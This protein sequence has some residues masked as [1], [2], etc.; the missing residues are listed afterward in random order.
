M[1]FDTVIIGGGLS[2]LVCGVKLLQQGQ[3]CVIISSGQSALHFSSGSFDLLNKLPDG[4][5]VVNPKQSV[6]KLIEN[7][8]E[9]PYSKIGEERFQSLADEALILLKDS[10]IPVRGSAERN[11]YRVSPMGTLKSTWLTLSDLL[12]SDVESKLPWKRVS[13]FNAIGFLDFHPRFIADEFFKLG[14]ESDIHLFNLPE[15]DLL[16][17]NP[18]EMRST[19]IARVFEHKE[20]IEKLI[21]IIKTNSKETDA[22]VLPAIIGL[23]N[24]EI[25]NFLEREIAKPVCIIPTLPP[26]ILGIRTQQQLHDHFVT[27]GGVYMLGDHVLNAELE[28]YKVKKVFS[29]NHGDI[30]F[31]AKNYVLATGSYFSQGL[32]STNN[33]VFEPVFNLDVAFT[34]DRQEWYQQDMFDKQPYQS[35]GVRTTECFKGLKNGKEF[36][37]LYVAGAI[38]E[39]FNPLKE[40]SGGGVSI[41]SALYVAETILNGD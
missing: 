5:E 39:G 37:N 35:F 40:G 24:T 13:I 41:L 32:L 6:A 2:G 12:I 29:R 16:R 15:L 38:L 17:R 8:P 26:S 21:E 27:L 19:N 20:S 22:I 30:P 36:E 1:K 31:T 14:V 33:S 11:H 28:G 7:N 3:R 23:D 25:V 18:S 34:S 4:T 9:H 10:G